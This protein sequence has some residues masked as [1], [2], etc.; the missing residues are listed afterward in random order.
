MAFKA[1]VNPKNIQIPVSQDMKTLDGESVTAGLV[2]RDARNPDS[3]RI[4]PAFLSKIQSSGDNKIITASGLLQYNPT[5]K[6]FQIS[7]PEKLINR[8][9]KGNYLSLHTETCSLNGDGKIE[10]GMNYGDVEVTS[11]GVANYDNKTKATT[12]NITSKFNF[13]KIDKSAFEKMAVLIASNESLKPIDLSTSTIEQTIVEIK[14]KKEADAFK[15]ELVQKGFVKNVMKEFED[16]IVITGIQLKSN[17]DGL[18]NGLITSVNSASIV[19]ILNKSVNKQIP[20]K[21]FFKQ[22][23]SGNISGDKLQFELD[24]PGGKHYFFDYGME[25]KEG[26]LQIYSNDNDF[27]ESILL[28]KAEKKKYKNFSYDTTENSGIMSSFMRLF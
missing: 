26:T 17:Y 6:E 5:S 8:A 22:S 1:P 7:S 14:D 28:L 4:Y 9:E 2:W 21:A 24:I 27:N 10:L 19:N 25:K 20:F 13:P 16:G 23:Y 3:V 18:N 12:M 11:Y 15:N